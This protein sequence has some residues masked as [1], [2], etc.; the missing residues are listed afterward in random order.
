MLIFRPSPMSS[1]AET[2]GAE[3]FRFPLCN[4]IEVNGAMNIVHSPV[5]LT[6]FV[7]RRFCL[8]SEGFSSDSSGLLEFTLRELWQ[9]AANHGF[10]IMTV[11]L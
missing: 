8:V 5:A 7:E 4:R 10:R 11:L 6:W 3:N 1:M 9:Q 2:A